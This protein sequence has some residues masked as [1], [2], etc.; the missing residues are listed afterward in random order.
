MSISGLQSLKEICNVFSQQKSFAG[1]GSLNQAFDRLRKKKM[2]MQLY[3]NVILVYTNLF[4][5]VNTIHLNYTKC[6][7]NNST[8]IH[9]LGHEGKSYVF[10]RKG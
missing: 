7:S 9:M 6:A 8:A 5:S 1:L 2:L 3:W 4:M 10:L